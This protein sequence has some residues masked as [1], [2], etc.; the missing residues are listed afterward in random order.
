MNAPF[1]EKAIIHGGTQSMP[2]EYDNS[3]KFYSETNQ[4]FLAPQD[5][6]LNGATHLGFWF[7]GNPAPTPIAVTETGGKM[8]LT[9]AGADIWNNSDEFV[10]AYKTLTGDGTIVAR[11]TST[12]TGTNTWAKGGVMIR[13]SVNGGSTF[14][15]MVITGSAGGGAGFQWRPVADAACSASADASPA[16]APPYWVKIERIG[17]NLAGY[18]SSDGKAWTPQGVPQTIKMDVPVLIGIC[19]TSHAVGEDRTF[20]FENIATTGNVTGAWQ[21]AQINSPAYNDAAGLYVVVE[22][23]SAKSKLV[24][25]PDPAAA[26]TG[27]WTRWAIP[28]SDF[29]SAGVKMTK[30]QKLV[31]GVGDRSKAKASGA[32]M[33]YI[34]DIGYGTP[35]ATK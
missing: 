25:H 24:V 22:D 16:V 28:L 21:G 31:I 2:M 23:S 6:T 32:G 1:A 29:T 10:F 11:V 3:V 26:A 20:Q 30:V 14:A 9:G 12:G 15:D 35:A 5:W 27:T 17:D 34:D 13:D 19:V 7:R 8:S 18:T 33:L 4:E